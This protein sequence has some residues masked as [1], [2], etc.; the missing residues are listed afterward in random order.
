MGKKNKLPIPISKE[1]IEARGEPLEP[2][3]KTLEENLKD[4]IYVSYN[5]LLKLEELKQISLSILQIFKVI[6]ERILKEEPEVQEETQEEKKEE[7]E[8]IY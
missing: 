4:P 5:I 7:R 2:Q 8:G 1:E 3:E 6:A